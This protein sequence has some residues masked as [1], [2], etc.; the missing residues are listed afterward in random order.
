MGTDPKAESDTDWRRDPQLAPARPREDL[1]G[2]SAGAAQTRE[3]ATSGRGHSH[4]GRGDKGT[5]DSLP[6]APEQGRCA[7]RCFSY[8]PRNP[9]T[10]I[11][12]TPLSRAVL[13]RLRHV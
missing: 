5:A 8:Y 2:R 13:G 7:D 12:A 3:E 4:A 1:G 11:D 10:P 9:L 6:K